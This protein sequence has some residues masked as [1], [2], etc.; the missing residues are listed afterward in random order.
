MLAARHA[1]VTLAECSKVARKVACVDVRCEGVMRWPERLFLGAKLPSS[2]FIY[3]SLMDYTL[4][5][6]SPYS[7]NSL[8]CGETL[9]HMSCSD[10]LH[11]S[12]YLVYVAYIHDQ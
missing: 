2:S 9:Y 1:C 8:A 6:S 7:G 4:E 5:S 11:M 12:F 10:I 3:A